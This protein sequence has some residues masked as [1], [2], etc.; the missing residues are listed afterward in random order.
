MFGQV[1]L[2]SP[3]DPANTSVHKTELVAAGVDGF[4]ARKLEVPL[5]AGLGVREWS[6]E[7]SGR[8]IDVNGNVVAGLLLKGIQNVVNLLYRLVVTCVRA[9]QDYK[10]TN[11]V[12]VNVL[13]HQLRVKAVRRILRDRQDPGFDLEVAGKLRMVSE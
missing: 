13:L 3:D 5:F 10:H 9:A 6:N 11:G 4:D 2:V 12:L 8:S 1:A 7:A